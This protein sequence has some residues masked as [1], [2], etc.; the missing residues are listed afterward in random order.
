MP[1]ALRDPLA[2]FILSDR[3]RP[4]CAERQPSTLRRLVPESTFPTSHIHG[5]KTHHDDR[6]GG[7]PGID[8]LNQ[9]TECSAIHLTRLLYTHVSSNGTWTLLAS[10]F[11]TCKQSRH[12][13]PMGCS[14]GVSLPLVQ[15]DT[16]SSKDEKRPLTP[17]EDGASVTHCHGP[18]HPEH[19]G[20]TEDKTASS[21]IY[22]LCCILVH[23]TI[24][25]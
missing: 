13:I 11:I 24:G 16:R 14:Y 19:R 1:Q 9:S 5:N 22:W 21:D 10:N 23:T 20:Q 4:V 8:W 2:C 3:R 25:Q 12:A 15:V 17:S 18:S 6:A 7:A